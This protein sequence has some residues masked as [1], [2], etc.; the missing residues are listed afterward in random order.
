[1]ADPKPP[2]AAPPRAPGGSPAGETPTGGTPAGEP[3]QPRT[4]DDALARLEPLAASRGQ[5]VASDGSI[6][7]RLTVERNAVDLEAEGTS[8]P[9]AAPPATEK[10]IVRAFVQAWFW[11]NPALDLAS[12]R[13]VV[14]PGEDGERPRLRLERTDAGKDICKAILAEAARL[15]PVR[16]KVPSLRVVVGPT[17]A[18]RAAKTGDPA[19]VKLRA[20][21]LAKNEVPL[22]EWARMENVELAD[23]AV[24]LAD[25]LDANEARVVRKTD[26]TATSGV[27]PASTPGFVPGLRHER[28]ARQVQ[29]REDA[30][31]A[32]AW[33]RAGWGRLSRGRALEAV[34]DFSQALATDAGKTGEAGIEAREGLLAALDAHAEAC[35]RGGQEPEGGAVAELK[36]VA[37]ELGKA[38]VEAGLMNRARLALERSLDAGSPLEAQLQLVDALL[39]AGQLVRALERAEA[40]APRLERDARRALALKIVQ[41]GAK[42]P[43]L[44]RALAIAGAA[45]ERRTIRSMLVGGTVAVVL[46]GAFSVHATAVGALVSAS[47]EVARRLPGEGPSQNLGE[48]LRTVASRYSFDPVAPIAAA[49]AEHVSDLAQDASLLEAN[50]SLLSWRTAPDAPVARAALAK[51][52]DAAR[53]PELQAILKSSLAR[54]DTWGGEANLEIAKLKAAIEQ[55]EVRDSL[56]LATSVMAKYPT[57]REVWKDIAIP[58]RINPTP[59]DAIVQWNS[60]T[61]PESSTLIYYQLGAPSGSLHLDAPGYVSVDRKVTLQDGPVLTIS[62]ERKNAGSDRHGGNDHHTPAPPLTP[63]PSPTRSPGTPAPVPSPAPTNKPRIKISAGDPGPQPPQPQDGSDGGAQIQKPSE[64]EKFSVVDASEAE[65]SRVIGQRTVIETSPGYFDY[66]KPLIQKRFRLQ[67]EVVTAV[68]KGHVYLDGVRLHLSDVALGKPI[69]AKLVELDPPCERPLR[70]LE[71]G[72]WKVEMLSRSLHLDGAKLRSDLEDELNS[73]MVDFNKREQDSQK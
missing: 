50:R 44:D 20:A 52:V 25:L 55:K 54:L 31:A 62:L 17:A 13:G 37:G 47:E 19:T 39:G 14:S 58:I 18:A 3:R 70:G 65:L 53:T 22:L 72:G 6:D 12:G 68:R 8:L 34:E 4:L 42:G 61:L 21:L 71:G 45:R 10:A 26:P 24:A 69:P 66:L 9:Q 16:R 49:R 56:D 2:A 27:K 11:S 1:M 63:S 60:Q 23:A 59:T 5:L 29:G 33:R 35:R 51:L 30:L 32:R 43:S 48:P 46:G 57:W 28:L 64:P 36:R 41:A 7:L 73:A 15:E 40:I 38:Y 67:V